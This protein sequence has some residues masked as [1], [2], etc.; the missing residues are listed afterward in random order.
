MKNENFVFENKITAEEKEKMVKYVSKTRELSKEKMAGEIEKKEEELKFFEF[1]NKYIK[2]ELQLLGI[3]ESVDMN[4]DQ[5][6][7]LDR[8][9]YHNVAKNPDSLA[10]V[11]P[12]W[13]SAYV[14]VEEMSHR[15]Q[16]YKT[17]LHEALHLYS[18]QKNQIY[19]EDKENYLL[20]YRYG[21]SNDNKVKDRFG[22]EHSHFVALNESMTDLI[23]LD[24]LR[25]HR[26]ELIEE[27]DITPEEAIKPISY[28]DYKE[29]LILIMQKIAENLDEN[30]D[31]VWERFKK[32]YFTGEMMHL[33][34]IERVFGNGS[35]RFLAAIS[36]F[37]KDADAEVDKEVFT[38]FE[39]DDEQVRE[40]IAQKVL[41][42]R[43]WNGY[44]KRR[45]KDNK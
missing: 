14:N 24:I 12:L 36:S 5:F 40:Q 19:T 21:Y 34:D 13:A 42:N 11:F 26:Q 32:G 1:A 8:E 30:Y 28:N 6:H 18:F 37:V 7:F 17:I 23:V 2:E 41:D 44:L 43:E 39:T 35:V 29:L 20:N 38:F 31:D 4:P 33:R 16:L 9:T 3:E 25:K 10:F 15:L 45:Y 22:E 27:F